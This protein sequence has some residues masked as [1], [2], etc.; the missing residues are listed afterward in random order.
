[1]YL[2]LDM[3]GVSSYWIIETGLKRRQHNYEDICRNVFG[4]VGIYGHCAYTFW[5]IFTGCIAYL[6]IAGQSLADVLHGLGAT[7]VVADSR[8]I[9]AVFTTCITLPLLCLRDL[10]S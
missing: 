1:M 8:F 7:G 5:F 2:F 3:L 9:I 4:K 6:I 10:V